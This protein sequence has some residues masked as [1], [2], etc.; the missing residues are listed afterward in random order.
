MIR[1]SR[2]ISVFSLSA[3]DLFASALGAFI[4]LALVMMPSFPNVSRVVVLAPPPPEPPPPAPPAPP[5]T[6]F[7]D[8]DLVVVL[9]LTDSM[10]EVLDGLKGDV[11]QL[12]RFLAL[13][14]PSLSV[15]VVGYGD[16][17][18]SQRRLTTFP[19]QPVGGS[20]GGQAALRTFVMGLG[21]N[22]GCSVPNNCPE[23]E[24]N[25][26]PEDFLHALREAVGMAWRSES[27][28]KVILVITDAHAY[29][30]E[31]EPAVAQAASF[32]N[33]GPAR[34]VSTV[35][36]DTR[37]YI[38][39]GLGRGDIETFLRRVADAGE[40]RFT[41]FGASFMATTILALM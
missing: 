28:R 26:W 23:N 32:A 34:E 6:Q 30:Q 16:R 37:R 41:E 25:D 36:V 5:D 12:T 29:P 20:T 33:R 10:E 27:A 18:W 19:L 15:G 24:N 39:F 17:Y 4:V 7:P 8:L 14:T 31:V 40:G 22:M 9:D 11:D 2:E 13:T 35:F 3:L 1:R 21:I 38:P